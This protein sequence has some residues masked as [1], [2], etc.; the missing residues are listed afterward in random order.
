[1]LSVQPAQY[2][3]LYDS[4]HDCHKM[5]CE[6]DCLHACGVRLHMH[7]A[8]ALTLTVAEATVVAPAPGVPGKVAAQG[9]VTMPEGSISL[10]RLAR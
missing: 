7:M 5:C 9:R 4:W 2:G 6:Q 8:H 1:M 3:I 10:W